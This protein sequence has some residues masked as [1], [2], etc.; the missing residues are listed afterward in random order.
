M[1][2]TPA[3]S[4]ILACHLATPQRGDPYKAV[5]GVPKRRFHP[6]SWKDKGFE[7]GCGAGGASL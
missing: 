3:L 5:G 4:L 6:K 1:G 2:R 7:A